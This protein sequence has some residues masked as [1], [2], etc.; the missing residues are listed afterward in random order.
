MPS[1]EDVVHDNLPTEDIMVFDTCIEPRPDEAGITD[2][3][4]AE[5]LHDADDIA[6]NSLKTRQ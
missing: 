3:V 1:A 6:A 2:P 4:F 5:A